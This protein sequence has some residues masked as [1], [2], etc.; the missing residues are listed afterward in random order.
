MNKASM[1]ISG[2]PG[3]GKSSLFRK[4]GEEKVSDSDSSM[5]PKGNF[6]TNYL[7]HIKMLQG[8]KDIILVSSHK[9]VRQGL[10]ECKI[11]YILVYP[12]VV[13]KEE[14]LERYKKRGSSKEFIDLMRSRWEEF[15]SDCQKQLGC[16]HI[17]LNK[18]Q[19]LEDVI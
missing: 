7:N 18:G 11:P 10:Y 3:V 8:R 9:E 17:E 1:I 19:F 16:A 2:F 4:Y 5:F 12:K 13:L 14:Y 6:P 15:I